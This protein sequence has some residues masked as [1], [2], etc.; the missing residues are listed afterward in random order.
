VSSA[1]IL[2]V[3]PEAYFDLPHFSASTAKV[4]IAKSPAHARAENKRKPTKALDA[5]NVIHRLVLG[6]GRDY[7]VIDADDWRTNAAKA[8]R[9]E[10]RDL[11]LIPVLTADF[12]RYV[13]AADR[14]TAQLADRDIV[15]DGASELAFEW[16]E[17]T[18]LG[19][20]ACR[21][22]M[23]HVWL[24]RG[25]ILDLKITADASPSGVERTA[26]N[27]GY[28]IQSAAYTSGLSKLRPDLAGR[29]KFIFAFA[30]SEE[31]FALNLREPDGVFRELGER[32]WRRAVTTWARCTAN[33]EWPA[34][35]AGPISP[36]P[37]AL[38]RE[39][40]EGG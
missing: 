33:N 38:A 29:I 32:R 31:P 7:Q 24:E 3:S 2:D 28:A 16:T 40:F 19:P 8:K 30:E 18:S 15:L 21:G 27:F 1:R 13:V 37:W 25:V 9:D 26:E 36:P 35:D 23:D 11:G 22:M 17:S 10:A 20:V 4:L 39:E 12:D 34:Y 5:G 6:K 14:I